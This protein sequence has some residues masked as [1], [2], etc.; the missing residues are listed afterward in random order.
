M[1]ENGAEQATE[2][3]YSPAEIG[4]KA[5]GVIESI[6]K[7]VSGLPEFLERPDFFTD[8]QK[9]DGTRNS[10]VFTLEGNTYD[11][12]YSTA[13]HTNNEEAAHLTLFRRD[14]TSEDKHDLLEVTAVHPKHD[15]QSF[16]NGSALLVSQTGATKVGPAAFSGMEELFREFYPGTK[17]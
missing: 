2:R 4:Q 17:D 3:I 9:Q 10:A 5:Y 16:T 11:I 8:A 12:S 14:K 15:S 6:R 1:G 13:T 7:K